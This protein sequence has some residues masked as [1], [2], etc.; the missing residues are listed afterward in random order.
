MDLGQRE[1][2]EREAQP[3]CRGA[4][5][6]LDDG[7]GR[8]AVRALIVAVLHQSD[9]RVRRPQHVIASAD[10]QYQTRD[11]GLTE[12]HDVSLRQ[13]GRGVADS[14]SSA[15]RMPSAPGFTPIGDR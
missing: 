11:A 10:R 7:M 15:S 2:A 12:G 14:D 9:G 6:R 13:A 8:A 3:S 4:A 5:D 1:V